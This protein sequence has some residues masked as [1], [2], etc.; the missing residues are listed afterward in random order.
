MAGP[1]ILHSLYGKAFGLDRFGFS[2]SKDND[3]VAAT[4]ATTGTDILPAG[5][6]TLSS[7]STVWRLD[8]PIPGLRK[9]ITSL[10]TST[11]N[12]AVQ[13]ESG[14][15]VSSG[16]ST[17]TTLICQGLA[18][19]ADLLGLSTAAYLVSVNRNGI[20]STSTST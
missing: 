1:T 9:T 14:N 6:T 3:V 2:V 16:G 17:F 8:A 7:A 11:A 12:R 4:S 13:L 19:G 10:S 18:Y 5:V 15:F 20:L